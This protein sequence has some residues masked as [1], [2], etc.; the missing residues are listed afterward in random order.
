MTNALQEFPCFSFYLFQSVSLDFESVV[1][2]NSDNMVLHFSINTLT[3]S[4]TST[5]GGKI[6]VDST[7]TETIS[8]TSLG[9][10][11]EKTAC[12]LN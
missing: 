5:S 11:T 4:D 3:A 7:E 6:P 2:F 8:Y 12:I 10:K 1:L 9:P